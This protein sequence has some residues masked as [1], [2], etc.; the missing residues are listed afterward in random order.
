MMKLS[1]NLSVLKLKQTGKAIF[2][3]VDSFVEF[4]IPVDTVFQD[5][6][7]FQY[8][9]EFKLVN[10]VRARHYGSFDDIKKRVIELNQ[11]IENASLNSVTQPYFIAQDV[12][13]GVYDV[14]IGIDENV[15]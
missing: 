1:D 7:H 2:T 3:V 11:Y 12:V 5:N 13:N 8:K 9:P 4:N 14:W 15:L 6:S 10:A